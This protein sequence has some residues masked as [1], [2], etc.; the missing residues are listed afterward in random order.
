MLSDD[1]DEEDDVRVL[2]TG[3][4]GKV[5]SAAVTA[6]QRAGHQVLA[7]DL[8]PPVH[9]RDLP[10]DPPY[11]QA[12]LTD[13]GVVHDLVRRAEAVV[14]AAAIPDPIHH[15]A[16]V[17]FANNV[18]SG[19]NVVDAC[20][21]WG[22]ARLVNLSSETVPGIIFAERPFLPPYLP[23]D[24][25]TPCAPQDPYGFGKHVIEQWCDAA[26]R[27]SDLSIVTIR[28]SWV[29]HSGNYERNLGPMVREPFEFSPNFWSYT[30][31]DDLA[32]AI[33]LAVEID[34][35]GHEVVYIAQPDNATGR[36]LAELVEATLP[37]GEVE[38]RPTDRSDASGIDCAK[39]Q[40]LLG[41]TPTRSWRDVLDDHGRTR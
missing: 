14:H 32:E 13:A 40:R 2:V 22:V 7:T 5:G 37:A 18:L 25:E 10:D 29:A 8:G 12:D 1:D 27:R 23:I 35:D 17:V 36:P 6:L 20:V 26:T 30:D 34:L 28:P 3:A 19:F 4:R 15:A 11:V 16:H 9:E 38:L 39:A 41:W 24:E 21:R 33:R 31:N